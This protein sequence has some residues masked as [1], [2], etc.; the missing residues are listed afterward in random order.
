MITL[1]WKRYGA[2]EKE[3]A[4]KST[5]IKIRL[6]QIYDIWKYVLTGMMNVRA[7]Y[8]FLTNPSMYGRCSVAATW[9]ADVRDVSGIGITISK[10]KKK[11]E[12]KGEM[13]MKVEQYRKNLKKI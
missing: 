8:L 11:K 2:S 4:I 1:K 10:K 3:E 12:K 13:N 9:I 6:Q 5:V 7:I